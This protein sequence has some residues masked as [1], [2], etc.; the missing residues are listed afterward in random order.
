MLNRLCA[1]IARRQGNH[2]TVKLPFDVY[3]MVEEDRGRI[4]TPRYVSIGIGALRT[5]ASGRWMLSFGKMTLG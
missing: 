4:E 2:R 3:E 1:G 5:R